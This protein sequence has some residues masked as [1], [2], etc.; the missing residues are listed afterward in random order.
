[1]KT[2][3]PIVKDLVLIGGGHSHVTV[4]KR[5]GMRPLKGVRLTVICRDVHTPYSGML[6]G[7]I[8]GHY[9]FDDAHIDLGPLARFAKARFFHDEAI[10]LD[11]VNKQILC[12]DRP[13]VP[14]DVL[15]INIGSTP[16][17][18]H[19]P[20]AEAGV[21]PVKPINK[22][23][24][25][26][27]ALAER[28]VATS[29]HARIGIVGAG[30]GGVELTLA[31]QHRLRGMLA[32][33][34]YSD[35]ALEFHLLTDGAE[36]LPTHNRRV[37]GKF[38]RVLKQRGVTVHTGHKVTEVRPG[39]VRCEN[40][41]DLALDEI[42]WVTMAGAASWLGE[43]GLEVDEGGFVRVDDTLESLSHPG[44]FAAGDVA[45]VVKHPR[46]KAG[47]F[48]VRQ[49]KPLTRNL[50]RALRGRRLRPFT[51]Q[52]KFLALISTGDKYAIA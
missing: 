42:L 26:W 15:S 2:Q 37:R 27:Q 46:E 33:R 3:G 31:V 25:H 19:V 40:G 9:D 50:K 28:V 4:L 24:D 21:V 6:P 34:E 44:V 23:I 45:N 48:A 35:E 12:R 29:G 51:P 18:S 32:A 5:F 11:L 38:E 8:A 20:G 36:I 22:F 1:M 13:P 39:G 52:R 30:A 49:G 17:I 14:Y 10:G 7:F 47:V 16:R 43:S 41:R